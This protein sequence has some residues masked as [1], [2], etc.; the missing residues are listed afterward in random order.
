M[1]N[2]L[3]FSFP[4]L[5]FLITINISAQTPTDAIMMG[6]GQVCLAAIY[7]HDSW[8]E[9]WEGT[10]LRTNGNIGTFTRH[11]IMPM[12]AIGLFDR[13]NVIVAAPWMKTESSDGYIKGISGF[14]DWGIWLK[15][16]ALETSAGPGNLNL[17]AAVGLNGPFSNY[18]SDYA[19]YSLGLSCLDLSLRGIAMY[20]LNAG[21]Y[22]RASMAYQLRGN[23]MVERDYYYTTYGV[24]SDKVD[25]PNA[26]NY[27]FALGS[28]FLNDALRI[29]ANY[30]SFNTIGGHDIRRQDVGFP[31][32]NMEFT[33]FGGL[34]QL[35]VGDTGLGFV[36]S[37][38]QVLTGRNVGKSTMF[39][40]GITYFF[41]LWNKTETEVIDN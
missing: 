14:Q 20:R 28:W 37:A 40:G 35:Y 3:H 34:V 39:S 22:V 18:P 1:K 19:P 26:I 4:C 38:S 24:Y 30:E 16:K 36:A 29:E 31:S 6:R 41:G 23:S 7:S 17:L 32:N 27:S 11:T 9:Y 25:M 2:I 15:G 13:L 5:L 10:L 33:R 8:D 21:P 12:A